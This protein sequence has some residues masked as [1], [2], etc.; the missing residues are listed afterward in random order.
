MVT[1]LPAR[2]AGCGCAAEPVCAAC[3]GGLRRPPPLPVPA[4]LDACAAAF[5]YEGVAR[6][7]VARLKYR[8]ERAAL[9]WLADA[10]VASH[11]D[12]LAQIHEVELVTWVPASAARRRAIGFDHGELL[13]RAVGREL[14]LPAS[15]LLAREPGDAQ[16]GRGRA[17]R[18]AGPRLHAAPQR[19]RG[20]SVLLVDD[21]RTT[22][23]TL[24]AA[25]SAL[26]R[27][28]AVRVVGL[29]AAATPKPGR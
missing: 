29:T 21:V 11:R 12:E 7:I 16:T 22:G 14:R 19:A 20:R 24:S 10:M 3:A 26:R 15:G 27:E 13:A 2:C 1:L 8:N 5:A 25:G 18:L 28:G 23:A 17:Q 4:A 9:P 6:E